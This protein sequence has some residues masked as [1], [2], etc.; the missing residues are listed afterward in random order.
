MVLIL[1]GDSDYVAHALMLIA[2]FG[3]KNLICAFSRSD[4]MHWTD[5]ITEVAP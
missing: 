1:V 2:S 4:Q 3:E 5:L